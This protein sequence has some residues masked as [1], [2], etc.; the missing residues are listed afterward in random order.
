MTEKK[1]MT[2]R[3]LDVDYLYIG[4]EDLQSIEDFG[5]RIELQTQDSKTCI[6]IQKDVREWLVREIRYVEGYAND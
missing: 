1:R 3:E 4:K 2:A 5:D 6:V